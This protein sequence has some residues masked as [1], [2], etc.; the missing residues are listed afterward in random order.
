M[1]RNEIYPQEAAQFNTGRLLILV[2][3]NNLF[4]NKNLDVILYVKLYQ[5]VDNH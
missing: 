3:S 1:L 4:V 2:W 5:A